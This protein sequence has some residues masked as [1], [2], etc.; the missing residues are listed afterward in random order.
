MK[1]SL[2]SLNDSKESFIAVVLAGLAPGGYL[3]AAFVAPGAL[4]AP[5]RY[6][7]CPRRALAI[8]DLTDPNFPEGRLRC[9]WVPESPLQVL[10]SA[11]RRP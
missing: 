4:K 11:G 10:R 9:A 7:P 3:K 5:F 8:G 1:D 2:L 6:P